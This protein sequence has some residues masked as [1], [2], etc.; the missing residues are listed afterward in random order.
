VQIRGGGAEAAYDARD[1][2]IENVD[3]LRPN[4]MENWQMMLRSSRKRMA[5]FAATVAAALA[6]SA[7]SHA[8]KRAA[9]PGEPS[10]SPEEAFYNGWYHERDL[11]K[12][13]QLGE[14]FVQNYPTSRHN[15][16]VYDQLL[17]AYN[18]KQDWTNFYAISDK[19]IAQYPDDVTV[20]ALTGWVIPHL[21]SADDPDADKKLLKA[22]AYEKHALEVIPK[23]VK[24]PAAK[25]EKFASIQKAMLTMAYSGL[26]LVYFRKTNY[27]DSVKQLQQATQTALS[28]DP[29][30][31]Y[32]LAVGLE[33]LGRYGDAAD[34]YQKCSQIE[35]NVE[36]LCKASA[37]RIKGLAATAK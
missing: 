11:Q 24:A 36:T 37:D 19:A 22:E 17:L 9:P 16:E 7:A 4:R 2:P 6:L 3:L 28:P 13:T 35:G 33:H 25:Q 10:V 18:A 30:D 8:Q 21:Y 27:Q 12:K 26:G 34:A 1:S 20:L 23:L 32:A 31:F 14:K 29:I 5:L 15:Q